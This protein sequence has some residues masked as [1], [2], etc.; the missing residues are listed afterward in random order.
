MY[1]VQE[2]I[3]PSFE[4]TKA[5]ALGFLLSFVGL[6][7]ADMYFKKG[8]KSKAN[9]K[10]LHMV[11]NFG[12]VFGSINDV[13][14]AFT[15]PH[16]TCTVSASPI[17]CYIIGALHL[18]HLMAYSTSRADWFHHVLFCGTLVPIGVIS[19]NPIVNVF[20]FFL[21]GLPGGI[22]Y[23]MLALVKH[24][25][26][27]RGVEK[28]WNARINVWLR[29]PGCMAAAGIM[30]MAIK[31]GPESICSNNPGMGVV[32]SLLIFFNGQYYAQVVV[33]NTYRKV[34]EYSC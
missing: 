17:P 30:F 25:L 4:E 22:D 13:V 14:F 20:A 24:E 33:G 23:L 15:D 1:K 11:A 6:W 5:H 7:L 16:L 32:L 8:L 12:V 3:R 34:E 2:I 27:S 10:L 19:P 29:S 18:Y 9:W 31:Y 21:S 28:I 26:M